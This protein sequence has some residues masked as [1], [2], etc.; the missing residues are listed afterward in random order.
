MRRIREPRNQRASILPE[1]APR[2]TVRKLASDLGV[3]HSLVSRVNIGMASSARVKA[4]LEREAAH[5]RRGARA[6]NA[7][8]A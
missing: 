5:L 7:P 4:A 2:G 8:A 6:K 1:D 3:S